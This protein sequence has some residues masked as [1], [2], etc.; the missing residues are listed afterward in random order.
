MLAL[1]GVCGAVNGL[2]MA[3]ATRRAERCRQPWSPSPAAPGWPDAPAGWRIARSPRPAISHWLA[4]PEPFTGAGGGGSASVL[5]NCDIRLAPVTP[6]TAAW[7]TLVM[8]AMPATRVGVGS[9]DAFDDPH[10][11]QRPAAVQRQRGEVPA[12][13]GQFAAA[14]RWGQAHPVQMAVDVKVLV[15]HPHWMVEVQRAVGQLVAELRHRGD[16]DRQLVAQLLEACSRQGPSRRPTPVP[17]TREVVGKAF[18]GRG[19]WRRV[20]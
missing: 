13:L 9:V 3:P 2:A 6:S 1:N 19:S 17:S 5:H 8:T 14:A 16:A 4:L 20:R 15:L 7:C 10:L 11:P 18:R 12:D